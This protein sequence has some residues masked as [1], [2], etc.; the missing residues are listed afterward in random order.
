MEKEE[1]FRCPLMEAV[2][3]WGVALTRSGI[4]CVIGYGGIF[5]F[6]WLVLS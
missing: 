2:G 1:G 3:I 5:G 4:F 6:L